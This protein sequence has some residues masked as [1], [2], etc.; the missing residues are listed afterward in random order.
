MLLDENG[1][2]ITDEDN[3]ADILIPALKNH[4]PMQ[5]T[6]TEAVLSLSDTK[7]G[8]LIR[9]EMMC[10]MMRLGYTPCDNIRSLQHLMPLREK[11]KRI[12]NEYNDADILLPAPNNHDPMQYTKTDASL[13][14]SDTKM[15]SPIRVLMMCKIMRLGYIPGANSRSLQ[16][17]ML[18]H[19]NVK[20]ITNEYN[21]ADILLS[22]PKNYDPMQYMK[23]EAVLFLSDTK[24]GSPVLDIMSTLLV[25]KV[26][27]PKV[28]WAPINN[29]HGH[30][31][32]KVG[33]SMRESAHEYEA[34]S[35]RAEAHE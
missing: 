31:W 22:A 7:K 6:K 20:M 4:D 10:K 15:G 21:G 18:L 12:T 3:G 23:T 29:K 34:V 5:Y 35:R 28:A 32:L 2:M 8:S 1:K 16:H 26:S 9:G 13:S 30:I 25:V 14:L 19:E 24:K 17:L 27:A 33:I 11:G